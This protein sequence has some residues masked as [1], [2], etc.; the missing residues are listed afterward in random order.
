MAAAIGFWVN[1]LFPPAQAKY[2]T[3]ALIRLEP[4][5]GL[6]AGT[7]ARAEPRD[8][9]TEVELVKTQFILTTALAQGPAADLPSVRRDPAAALQWLTA[10]L[11]VEP[12]GPQILRISLVGSDADELPVLVNAVKD[13]YLREVVGAEQTRRLKRKEFLETVYEDCER[14]RTALTQSAMKGEETG[15]ADERLLGERL[16]LLQSELFRI[17]TDL[18]RS[19]LVVDVNRVQPDAPVSPTT[20]EEL[21]E[22]DPLTRQHR[23]RISQIDVTIAE[24][25]RT[26]I[27][28]ASYEPYR[29]LARDR[30][31]LLDAVEDRKQTLTQRSTESAADGRQKR[32]GEAHARTVR[33]EEERKLMRELIARTRDELKQC[34]ADASAQTCRQ[35]AAER[36]ET[37]SK[38]VS[39]E[40]TVLR[41]ELK[42][43]A[44][45][46][47]I[48]D[49]AE[50]VVKQPSRQHLRTWLA[51][52][53][54]FLLVVAGVSVWEL[55]AWRIYGPED[56]R[57]GLGVHVLGV[58]PRL[59]DRTPAKRVADVWPNPLT[60]SVDAVCAALL[61]AP[62]S[63][64]SPQVI[65]ITSAAPGEGKSTLA[66][67]LA[68][69][70][71]RAGKKTLLL[72]A[73]LYRPAAHVAFD[74]PMGPGLCEVLSGEVT[75][76]KAIHRS[77]ADN[78]FV[79]TAGTATAGAFRE[80]AR[81]AIGGIL[82]DL[83]TEFDAIVI[84]TSPVLATVQPLQVGRY[85]DA[86]VL[87]SL[88]AVS[89][90]ALLVEAIRRLS[91]LGIPVAGVVVNGAEEVGR[92]KYYSRSGCPT[93]PAASPIS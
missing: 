14:R 37:I 63:G 93:P 32:T 62:R 13:T 39:D 85:A 53:G 42:T 66:R 22:K 50:P 71:A 70:L 83:R 16:S 33:L 20:V 15:T 91:D 12:V 26:R 4:A 17:E 78:V 61:H 89:R 28:P 40:L 67:H 65:E 55:W 74:L 21:A 30:K 92:Y 38:D 34:K 80:I 45:T 19:Q 9:R 56:V 7:P 60:D 3:H 44:R 75:L 18:R 84:D 47:S 10:E 49:A 41:L 43:I 29:A 46:A 59:P 24:Q 57:E 27:N 1:H 81:G 54:P 82:G 79:L 11:K 64:A 73:D 23:S 35:Y 86:V 90:S 87:C 51:L 76:A 5:E 88:S 77:P 52:A 6:P 2:T 68:I 25:E 72:D 31:N 58:V 36:L 48:Q 69:N 8:L